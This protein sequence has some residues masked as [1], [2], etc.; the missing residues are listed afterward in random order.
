MTLIFLSS[1]FSAPLS[2]SNAA[3]AGKNRLERIRMFTCVKTKSR[4][5]PNSSL[6]CLD[7]PLA[8]GLV[9]PPRGAPR[10]TGDF[11]EGVPVWPQV[12]FCLRTGDLKD[13]HT[14]LK[15]CLDEGINGIDEVAYVA[16]G[17]LV[18]LNQRG[19]EKSYRPH[20]ISTVLSAL[21]KCNALYREAANRYSTDGAESE[22]GN[23]DP[24]RLQVLSLLG[25]ADLNALCEGT[26]LVDTTVEDFLWT[27]LWFV[28][29]TQLLSNAFTEST[30][31]E[32]EDLPQATPSFAQS[33]SYTTG[34]KSSGPATPASFPS[35]SSPSRLASTSRSRFDLI[36]PLTQTPSLNQRDR[37]INSSGIRRMHSEHLPKVYR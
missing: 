23:P 1:P 35:F 34:F 12:Y 8:Y 2:S 3:L 5:I 36:D 18:K 13:A 9:P 19:N 32:A 27:S 21:S 31:S 17:E 30:A 7:N 11:Y 29:W 16:L 14:L 20:Q 33:K 25:L 28:H 10:S 15:A 26:Y 24:Y 4:Q 6:A 37:N 22:Y